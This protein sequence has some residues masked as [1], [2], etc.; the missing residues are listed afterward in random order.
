M[1][2]KNNAK[3]RA[4]KVSKRTNAK[5]C[6]YAIIIEKSEKSREKNL[7]NP[8]CDKSDISILEA[9]TKAIT[10]P[11]SAAEKIIMRSTTKIRSSLRMRFSIFSSNPAGGSI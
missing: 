5:F 11:A 3:L 4:G 2:A 8:D 6:Q 7:K 10:E 9:G 1:T